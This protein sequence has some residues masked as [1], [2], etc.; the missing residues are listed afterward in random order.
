MLSGTLKK[1]RS[2]LGTSN[3]P[4][5][6]NYFLPL[7]AEELPSVGLFSDSGFDVAIVSYGRSNRDIQ[8]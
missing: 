4:D 8:V 3:H 7:G 6:V 5:E 2:E 1:M